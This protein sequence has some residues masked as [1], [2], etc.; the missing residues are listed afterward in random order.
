M[1]LLGQLLALPHTYFSSRKTSGELRRQFNVIED[2]RTKT[3]RTR[4]YTA[5]A[6]ELDGSTTVPGCKGAKVKHNQKTRRGK[7]C[8]TRTMVHGEGG[9]RSGAPCCSSAIAAVRLRR[10]RVD[11]DRIG[12][13]HVSGKKPQPKH[14]R[15]IN[16]VF[17]VVPQPLAATRS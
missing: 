8:S 9:K 14:V 16:L 6:P 3:C 11:P 1:I 13:I 17:T 2:V 4:D 10:F 5:P 12:V 7:S 15:R